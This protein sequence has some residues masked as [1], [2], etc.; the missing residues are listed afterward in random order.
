MWRHRQQIIV[1]NIN[2]HA[3]WMINTK[4][5]KTNI[6]TVMWTER[7]RWVTDDGGGYFVNEQLV[8]S[9]SDLTIYIRARAVRYRRQ[10]HG[11]RAA[12]RKRQAERH[13]GHN[14]I[15]G[16]SCFST[17]EL[18]FSQAGLHQ[19]RSA[20]PGN[21]Q[22]PGY[23]SVRSRD[24]RRRLTGE[25]DWAENDFRLWKENRKVSSP[26]HFVIWS[27]GPASQHQSLDGL[28]RQEMCVSRNQV[29][30]ETNE[31]NTRRFIKRRSFEVLGYML[32]LCLTSWI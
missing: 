16:S 18:M 3:V 1:K 15:T 28:Q 19:H 14:I 2:I 17:A 30:D 5:R 27:W 12:V 11:D 29:G 24:E 9:D 10:Q 23:R 13:T 25:M 26:L 8:G 32:I 31:S 6:W 21:L 20:K 4:H 22:A 7:K